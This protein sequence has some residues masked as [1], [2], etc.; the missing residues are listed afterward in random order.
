VRRKVVVELD[1][2]TCKGAF[3]AHSPPLHVHL[4]VRNVTD[5]RQDVINATNHGDAAS[6]RAL[7]DELAGIEGPHAEA[8]R[9][10][11]L[12]EALL[13][14]GDSTAA[15][16]RFESALDFQKQQADSRAQARLVQSIGILHL[17][18]GEFAEA[19][20][21]FD[22]VMRFAEESGYWQNMASSLTNIGVVF[23]STGDYPQALETF[24]RAR[25][26]AVDNNDKLAESQAVI[27]IGTVYGYTHSFESALEYFLQARALDLE[28]GNKPGLARVHSNV[29]TAY[30]KLNRY[31]ESIVEYDKALE[32]GRSLGDSEMIA[33]LHANKLATYVE[34]GQYD[35]AQRMLEELKHLP[36]HFPM[37][38]QH[39][40]MYAGKML[41]A[42]DDLEGAR[43]ELEL[44][45]EVAI[46]NNLQSH[47]ADVHKEL[48][49][50]AKKR[51]DFEAYVH[52]ST[53]FQRI[54]EDIRGKEATRQLTMIEANRHI[55]DERREREKERAVLYST[56]PKHIADR[57]VRGE[58]VNGD[59][60][61]NASVLFLDVVGFTAISDTLSPSDVIELLSNMFSEVDR[62]C[63]ANNVT[64]VKTI[65][66]SYLAVAGLE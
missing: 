33:N 1:D 59:T 36:Y 6:L 61:D 42:L 2:A 43:T 16:A 24:E 23:T 64:K 25:R 47:L 51:N 48:R 17:S 26:L 38:K 11:A 19:L 28:L 66:D 41:C 45:L 63:N 34:A 14:S 29:G 49:D 12:G 57:V 9:N 35:E 8:V 40:H 54:T 65:G 44:S 5:I 3:T 18:V 20:V 62:V 30:A 10:E 58:S 4:V 53:E 31:E 55:E 21:K 15:L 60:Y 7:A 46:A 56:L 27:N 50:L 13:I 37:T 32:I 22:H 39:V 52:H